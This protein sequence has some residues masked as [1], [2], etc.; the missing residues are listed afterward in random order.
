[1]HYIISTP[2]WDQIKKTKKNNLDWN[3]CF[4]TGLIGNGF[5]NVILPPPSLSPHL[6]PPLPLGFNLI[7]NVATAVLVI[8][9]IMRRNRKTQKHLLGFQSG[10]AASLDGTIIINNGGAADGAL[11][12]VLLFNRYNHVGLNNLAYL[13]KIANIAGRSTNLI[14]AA[15]LSKKVFGKQKIN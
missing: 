6:S 4:C 9:F 2:I 10:E 7:R 12:W 1:M 8:P 14:F 15:A 11:L 5:S 13:I 3:C